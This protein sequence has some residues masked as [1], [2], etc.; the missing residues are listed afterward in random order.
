MK[1][2]GATVA[3]VLAVPILGFALCAGYG[4]A[5]AGDGP[6][7]HNRRGQVAGASYGEPSEGAG[8]GLQNQWGKK[9]VGASYGEPSEGAGPGLQNRW[10]KGGVVV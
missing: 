7:L 5:S 9:V 6:D 8:P 4:Q 3:A 10:G 2:V 1:R